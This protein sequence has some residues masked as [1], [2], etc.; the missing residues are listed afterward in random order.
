MQQKDTLFLVL[1][2]QLCPTLCNPMACSLPGSS[3]HG[4]FQA[5]ILMWVAISFSMGSSWPRDWTWVSCIAGRFFPP[6]KAILLLT[7]HCLTHWFRSQPTCNVCHSLSCV[8]LFA[9][10]WTAARYG[11]L[12]GGFPKQEYWSELPFPTP[13]DPNPTCSIGASKKKKMWTWV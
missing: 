6:G 3:V 12:S 13:A 7:A 8:W 9:A 5:R 11:P 2:A 10:P 1:V 4:I